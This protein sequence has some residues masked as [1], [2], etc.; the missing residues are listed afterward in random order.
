MAFVGP[1]GS[2]KTTLLLLI[3]GVYTAQFGTIHVDDVELG[4]L[5][6]AARRN[7]RICNVGFVFQDFELVE[8]LNV[9]DNIFLP[10]RIN[11][12]LKLCRSVR[13][14][15]VELA[16]SLE[17][18]GVFRRSIGRISQGER[19]RVAV[20]RALVTRPGLLLADEP[21]G[22][23]DTRNRENAIE[24]L[25]KSADQVKASLLVVTHDQS[26]LDKF[27]RVIDISTDCE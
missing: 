27:D 4:R 8:Y 9:R 12:R 11:Q 23:L 10:Y 14:R 6:D 20:C 2:G 1:S 18:C 26:L 5:N 19:Q 21:T 17:L 13:R 22:N 25:L 3:A 16:Q 15:A 7:Y 24:V